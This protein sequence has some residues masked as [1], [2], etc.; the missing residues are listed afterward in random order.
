MAGRTQ[1][2]N[3]R[4]TFL[5]RSPGAGGQGEGNIKVEPPSLWE[6]ARG[7][8]HWGVIRGARVMRVF[9][10]D[11]IDPY[12]PLNPS[13]K[14]HPLIPSLPPSLCELRRTSLLQ[15][16]RRSRRRSRARGG[17]ILPLPLRERMQELGFRREAAK[18]LVL[19]G[20]GFPPLTPP[21]GRGI[22]AV[23]PSLW[24]GAGGGI[25]GGS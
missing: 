3:S 12:A 15:G 16:P 11:P 20:E 18:P 10:V 23:P 14:P 17:E 9:F 2:S 13:A 5:I 6:G 22:E 1:R 19:A 25:I 7:R 4:K 8:D 24:E 21:K